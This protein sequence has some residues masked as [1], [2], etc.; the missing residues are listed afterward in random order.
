MSFQTNRIQA[1]LGLPILFRST[2]EVAY[3]SSTENGEIWLRSDAY[4]RELED[5]VRNDHAE[6]LNIG[7]TRL[8]LSFETYSGLQTR[9]Q[10]DGGIGEAL[11]AHYMIS[12]H[13]SSIAAET[14]EEFGGFTFGIKNIDLL[15]RHIFEECK[16][17][18]DCEAWAWNQVSYQYSALQVTD[19]GSGAGIRLGENPSRNLKVFNAHPFKK[20]PVLPFIL[21]DEWRIVIWTKG[22]LNGSTAEALK[23]R[24][25]PSLFYRYLEGPTRAES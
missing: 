1:D 21:Q 16:R 15:A 19:D 2:C 13:G 23:I 24:V 9:I 14:R 10:G 11:S 12:L 18:I 5:R 4:F 25:P 7:S 3:R 6:S 17:Q 20:R 22:Y 8:E